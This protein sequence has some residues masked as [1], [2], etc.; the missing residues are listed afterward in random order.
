MPTLDLKFLDT[1]QAKYATLQ[2][3]LQER[4]VDLATQKQ[5][6]GVSDQRLAKLLQQNPTIAS[7]RKPD[8]SIDVE[9]YRQLAAAQGLTP[10]GLEARVRQDIAQRQLLSGISDSAILP[11]SIANLSMS[12]FFE[13]REIQLARFAAS[14]FRAGLKPGDVLVRF[15][16]HDGEV[17]VKAGD[18]L[19]QPAGVAHNVVGRS[20]DLEVLEINMPAEFATTDIV[21]PARTRTG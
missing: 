7:L 16:G 4:V 10:E 2:R 3:M 19:S 15:A 18:C 8:G 14:D 13:R 5:M 6:I 1:P 12:A 9:R 11:D 21:D 17:T 20:D